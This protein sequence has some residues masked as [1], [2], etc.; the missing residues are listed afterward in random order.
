MIIDII[1]VEQVSRACDVSE[2]EE[3]LRS[4]LEAESAV[5]TRAKHTQQPAA[6]PMF[7]TC[8]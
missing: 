8:L 6:C 7:H 3:Q 4:V 5:K 1:E 2:F